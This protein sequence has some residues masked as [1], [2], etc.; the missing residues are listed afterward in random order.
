[1]KSLCAGGGDHSSCS[2]AVGRA[3]GLLLLHPQVE[4]VG[5]TRVLFKKRR[6]ST[7]LHVDEDGRDPDNLVTSFQLVRSVRAA[8]PQC[9]LLE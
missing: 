6:F 7:F 9:R 5:E 8:P 3:G 2:G 1:M 4:Q